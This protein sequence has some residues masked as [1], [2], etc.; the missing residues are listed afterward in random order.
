MA[1]PPGKLTLPPPPTA[2]E[3]LGNTALDSGSPSSPTNLFAQGGKYGS[4][5]AR[6]PRGPRQSFSTVGRSTRR[7]SRWTTAG[8]DLTEDDAGP[9]LPTLVP[10][11]RPAYSTP[12]PTLP[13]IVLCIVSSLLGVCPT[14]H[15][16]RRPCCLNCLPRTC[17]HLSCSR[18]WRVSR[19][20]FAWPVAKIL[21]FLPE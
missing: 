11:I 19:H 12:L 18:W 7:G 5:L 15:P 4:N 8:V 1:S 14:A 3:I 10:G 9:K 6:G 16:V 13:M 21:R 20:H 17:V 2:S